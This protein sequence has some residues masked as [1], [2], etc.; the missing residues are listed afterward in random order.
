VFYEL[1]IDPIHSKNFKLNAQIHDSILFQFR[2]G[3][4]HL[5]VRVKQLMEIPVTV[6]GCDGK[7]RTFTV[8]AALKDGSDHTG[9]THWSETE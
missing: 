8:P 3:H 6:K 2:E 9:A 1:A 4:H 5:A 7:T